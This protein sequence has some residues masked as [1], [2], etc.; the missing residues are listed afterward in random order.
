MPRRSR[1]W[2]GAA[3]LAAEAAAAAAGIAVF[4][5]L[6]HL[7]HAEHLAEEGILALGLAAYL[8]LL[9]G[10]M[11]SRLGVPPAIVEMILGLAA[12]WAGIRGGP[13]LGV[14]SGIGANLLLFMAGLEV[15]VGLLRRSL[16]RALLLGLAVWVGP[17]LLAVAFSGSSSLGSLLVMVAAFSTTSVAV[18]FTVLKPL[19]LLRSEHGQVAL[20]AAMLT[21]VLGMVALNA[22]T[23]VV[24]Y[25]LLLYTVILLAALALHPILPRVGGRP[26]EFELRV[27]LMALIVLGAASEV[28]GVH[29]VL[30]S[31]ILGVVVGE[32]VRSR[33]V[34]MEKLEGL[35]TGFFTPFF[36][37][38]AGMAVDPEALA[39]TLTLGLAAGAAVFALK[40]LPAYAYYR[41]LARLRPGRAAVL[42]SSLSPLLTVSI[43][44][45]LAGYEKGLIG[46]RE[47]GV[48]VTAVVF[49]TTA[50]AAVARLMGAP[51]RPR[52][53]LPGELGG[54]R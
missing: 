53:P 9:S 37:V 3:L 23:A 39:G 38:S 46:S 33:R 44:G 27:I 26:F 16:G 49:T 5:E 6:E 40:A 54:P 11:A 45:G 25:R 35:S 15:E 34:L 24:D 51:R 7:S 20:A 22:A 4:R 21:D 1:G 14:L 52:P 32:T 12:A 31:F 8:I 19:G 2:R 10:S 41:L 28:V 43:V 42:A 17:A 47:L 29:G 13:A 48:I 18:T 36:F 50:T 30:T